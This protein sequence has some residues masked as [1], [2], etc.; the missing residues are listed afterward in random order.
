MIASDNFCLLS[1]DVETTSIW[2]NTLRDETGKKVLDYAMPKLLELYCTYNIKSTF[3]FTWYIAKKFPEIVKMIMPYGHEIASHGKSHLRENGFDIMPL[4]RQKR[5]LEESKKL[6]EDISGQEVVSFR[7]PALRVN[8]DTVQAL[9]ETGYKI[10]SSIASQ[11]F[12]FF[13]TFGSTHKLKS[14]LAPRLPYK[15]SESSLFRKGTGP[16]IEIPLSAFIL[17]YVGATMR[18]FPYITSI[19]KMFLDIESR[20]IKKPIV[21][22]IHPHELIDESDEYRIFHKRVKNIFVYF[23]QDWVRAK[24]KIKNIGLPALLYYEKNIKYFNQK[25]YK[26]LTI[27]D[28]CKSLKLI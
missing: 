16:I 22:Y 10:D 9:I 21:V 4:E 11:R 8:N 27:K 25:N 14:L 7:A 12:D 20:I 24:L 19:Q 18:I 13:M 15:T 26:F 3:F 1:N 5:H 28:Y 2:F 23:L 17:P 6:L